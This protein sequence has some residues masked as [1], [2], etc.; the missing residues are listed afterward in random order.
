M[1][2]TQQQ[3]ALF[4]QKI[5]DYYATY[6]R[7]FPWR[8]ASDSYHIFISEVMLQQTQTYRV[9][10]K[11]AHFITLF[12]TFD[13]LAQ[14]PTD[15]LICAWQGLGYNRRALFLRQAAQI[16]CAEHH[17]IL[18]DDPALLVTLPGIGKATA[19]SITTFAFNKPTI[20]IETNI[21]AVFIHEFFTALD[22]VTD[23]QLYPLVAQTVDAQDPRRWYYALMDYGV[24]LKKKFKNP[25]RS[26]AHHQKQSRFEGSNRQVRGHIL[27]LLTTHRS[28]AYDQ[29]ID[30]LTADLTIAA[31]RAR[32]ILAAMVTERFCMVHE[33][34]V[35]FNL[36]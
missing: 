35:T 8:F 14:A 13:A 10:P 5:Y 7:Q 29:L 17:G 30:F 6:G 3:I 31:P 18:P 15:L 26:S 16:I 25:A 20:F 19:A 11:Y 21:R 32:D 24:M 4:K 2:L 27:K 22:A 1:T 28:L 33:G 9:E 36:L 34:S 12:P 23:T